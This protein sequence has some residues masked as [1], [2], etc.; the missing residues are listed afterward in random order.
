MMDVDGTLTPPRKP[1]RRAMAQGL[2]H[3]TV[4]FSVAA[5]SD[6]KLVQPQFLEPLHEFGFRGAFDAFVSNGATQYHCDYAQGLSIRAVSNFDIERHLGA[7]DLCFLLGVLNEVAE[8]PRFRV[9]APLRVLGDQVTRRGSMINFAPIG[10]PGGQLD[11]ETQRNRDEF[12]KFDEAT[13][14]RRAMLDHLNT[15]LEPL[16][17]RKSLLITLG[18]QTSF[19]IMVAGMDKTHAVRKLL[20]SGVERILFLGDALFAGGN[21]SVIM[22]FVADWAGPGPCPVEAVEARGWRHTLAVLRDRGLLSPD[23]VKVVGSAQ[24]PCAME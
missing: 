23:G 14:Y 22:H 15:R 9:P 1:L 20:A 5:G 10:R 4:P 12:V 18:G 13:G 17:T 6:L 7:A 19:D 8:D 11:G 21:D 2:I 24:M 16:K 3:L